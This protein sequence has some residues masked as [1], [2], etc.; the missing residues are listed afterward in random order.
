VRAS[1]REAAGAEDR[2]RH[3]CG[4][5]A[6]QR[7]ADARSRRSR[8]RHGF[9]DNELEERLRKDTGLAPI[10]PARF[11]SFTDAEQNTRE[12]I[13]RARSHPWISKDVPV[14]GFVFDVHTGRLSEVFPDDEAVAG[15]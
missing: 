12:Q 2:H 10:A 1:G 5:A 9:T 4:S 14:R 13:Q 11:Y 7:R 3:L 8:C 15:Q 6:E